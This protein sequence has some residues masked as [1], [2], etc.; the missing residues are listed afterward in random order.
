MDCFE[1]FDLYLNSAKN[2]R[3]NL[4]LEMSSI[5]AYL[6]S[7]IEFVESL[8]RDSLIQIDDNEIYEHVIKIDNRHVNNLY[9]VYLAMSS[10]SI[11]LLSITAHIQ[12][13]IN[14]W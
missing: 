11:Q 2:R 7:E 10:E 12:S 6:I 3:D 8:E 13:L 9:R 1:E 14:T 5:R 4:K